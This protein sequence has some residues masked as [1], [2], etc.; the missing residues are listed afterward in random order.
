MNNETQIEIANVASA[1]VN[2][3]S[4]RIV[5]YLAEHGQ[6]RFKTINEILPLS[7]ATVSQHLSMLM[8]YQIISLREE[9]Q[10]NFYYLSD[11]YKGKIL[12]LKDYLESIA[13]ELSE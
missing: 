2:P 7:K 4:V 3:A 6:V 13:I 10:Y 8:K 12:Q 9:G 5:E 11:A 1:L